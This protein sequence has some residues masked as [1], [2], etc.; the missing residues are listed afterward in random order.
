VRISRWI[1]RRRDAEVDA[2][3][4]K[5][6]A[7]IEEI[8]DRLRKKKWDLLGDEAEYAGR[9]REEGLTM[10]E[11]VLSFFMGR[12]RTREATIAANLALE[13]SLSIG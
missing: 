8:E 3:E 12:R 9:K 13:V 5:C 7:R 10:R 11:T 4:K 2:L 6:T 1:G